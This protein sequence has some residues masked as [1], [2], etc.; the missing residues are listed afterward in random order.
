MLRIRSGRARVCDTCTRGQL[1]K[2]LPQSH[3]VRKSVLRPHS[4]LRGCAFSTHSTISAIFVAV[5]VDQVILLGVEVYS[6]SFV[7]SD[8]DLYS[9][10]W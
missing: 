1:P 6:A 4:A 5:V 7:L 3:G 10:N 8:R 2:K 9:G